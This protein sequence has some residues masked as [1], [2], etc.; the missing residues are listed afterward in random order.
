MA[1]TEKSGNGYDR[2]SFLAGMASGLVQTGAITAN[3]EG[4]SWAQGYIVGRKLREFLR[5]GRAW[6]EVIDGV[7]YIRRVYSAQQTNTTLEVE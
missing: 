2:D 6:A 4:N 3:V 7:L 5:S 1:V